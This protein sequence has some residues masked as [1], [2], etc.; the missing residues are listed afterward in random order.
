MFTGKDASSPTYYYVFKTRTIKH[1]E[2]YTKIFKKYIILNATKY[3]VARCVEM[4]HILKLTVQKR[5][6]ENN[7]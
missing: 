6:Q 4:A 5:L 2:T 3:N 1:L 7:E